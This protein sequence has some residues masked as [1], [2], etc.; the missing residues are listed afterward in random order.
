MPQTP[1]S[2]SEH[3][4]LRPLPAL[5]SAPRVRNWAHYSRREALIRSHL[6]TGARVRLASALHFVREKQPTEK[7]PPRKAHREKPTAAALELLVAPRAR[8]GVEECAR[9]VKRIMVHQDH[10]VHQHRHLPLRLPGRVTSHTD[11]GVRSEISSVPF[12]EQLALKFLRVQQDTVN[13]WRSSG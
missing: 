2:V 5:F 13:A 1:P 6:I 3:L 4:R 11:A 7:S 8:A 10:Q 12:Q 9:P